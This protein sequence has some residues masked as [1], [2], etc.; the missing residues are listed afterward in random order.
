MMRALFTTTAQQRILV[1]DGATCMVPRMF[2]DNQRFFGFVDR[3]REAETHVP[4]ISG[5]KPLTIANQWRIFPP[6]FPV[7]LSEK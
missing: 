6:I 3:C 2:F 1:F 7:D 4:I 5:L